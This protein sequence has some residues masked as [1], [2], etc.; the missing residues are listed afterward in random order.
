MIHLKKK[1]KEEKS[2]SR[3]TIWVAL[4][5]LAS[6]GFSMLS[7]IILSR[8]FSKED[9]G[10]YKQVMYVYNTFLGVF[11]L[12]LPQ[13]FGYF[14]PRVELTE[15]N[16]VINKI[17]R[18][19][20]CC[21]LLFSIGLYCCS[22]LIADVLANEKLETAIKIFALVPFFLLPTMGLDSIYATFKKTHISAIYVL[23]TR[24]MMLMVVVLPV[25]LFNSNYIMALYGF[26]FSSILNFI[27]AL[28]LKRMPFENIVEKRKSIVSY[29][30][31]IKFAMPVM[32]TAIAGFFIDS[33]NS[34]FISRYFGVKI[35]AVFSNGAMSLPFIGMI[36]SAC[37]TVLYPLFSK[38]ASSKKTQKE[39]IFTIWKNV[40]RKTVLL[41]YPMV[42]FCW[43]FA[44]DIMELLYGAV[45]RESGYYF[46]I[47][48]LLNCFTIITYSPILFAI[49]KVKFFS[50]VHIFTAFSIIILDLFVVSFLH[51][52]Y[53]VLWVFVLCQIVKIILLLWK[54]ADY[55]GTSILGLFPIERIIS[56]VIPS[57]ALLLMLNLVFQNMQ[58]ISRL[59]ISLMS[60]LCLL[61]FLSKP[62]KLNYFEILKSLK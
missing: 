8:F 5:S 40:F 53:C 61:L 19:L 23:V 49:G 9:Y 29:S 42:C 3:Q 4:G 56:V 2:L 21:G 44:L 24:I 15:T 39:E 35:F 27:I 58:I 25:Y 47:Y 12:G 36:I 54:V 14:L 37:S 55:F 22:G 11:S 13:A 28:Y 33:S 59:V 7:S 48:L 52:P 60:Y 34:F 31:I 50:K 38:M 32:F 16:D 43:V 41:I 20:M 6:F 18:L 30:E 1:I 57:F 51:S 17:T 26:L 10:T 62:L 46:R 45:Y